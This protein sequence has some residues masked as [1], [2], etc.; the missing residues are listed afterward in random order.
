MAFDFRNRHVDFVA[1]T[2]GSNKLRD[3]KV[4][5]SSAV[6]R[7]EAVIKGFDIGYTGEDHHIWREKVQITNVHVIEGNGVCFD[8]EYLFRDSSGNI[9]DRYSGSVDVVVMAEVA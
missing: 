3:Q 4:V 6:R 7:A 5:F 1:T 8:I 9:D 2:G